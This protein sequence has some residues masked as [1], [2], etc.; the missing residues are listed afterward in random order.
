M[1]RIPMEKRQE[2]AELADKVKQFLAQGGK[3]QTAAHGATADPGPMIRAAAR[4]RAS[5]TRQ[6]TK[7]PK[8]ARKG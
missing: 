4:A 6:I 1:E 3:I 7:K 2:S 5:G 8:A